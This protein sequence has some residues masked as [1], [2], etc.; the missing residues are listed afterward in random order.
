VTSSSSLFFTSELIVMTAYRWLPFMAGIMVVIWG[1]EHAF[2]VQPNG[3]PVSNVNLRAG[4]DTEYPVIVTVPNRAP[5]AILGCLGDHTWCDVVFQDS[6]GWMRSIYLAGW[7]QGYYYPLR[8][9]APRLGYPI[10]D[11]DIDEYW[12]AYYEDRPFYQERPRWSHAR[13]EGWVDRAVFYDRLE[14]YGDWVWLQGQYVWVPVN[15][16]RQWRP[17]TDGR[18]V[19]TDRH[20]WM[21]VSS[22]PFG[23]ATYH[24]GRWGFSNQVG[25]FWVPGSRWGPAWVSWRSSD[26]YLAWAPLPPAYDEGLS[27]NIAV[28]MVPD[29]YWQVVPTDRFLSVDL[30]RDIIRD[31]RRFEPL[32]RDTRPLGN[33]TI[34]NNNV[35]VNK[36][37]NVTYIE[38]KTHEKVVV[39]QVEKTEDATKAGKVE[40]AAVEVFQPAAGQA[41]KTAAPHKPKKIE[42]VAVES[43]TKGQGGGKPTTEGLLIP[44]EIQT[45]ADKAAS[46]PPSPSL[47]EEAAVPK[48]KPEGKQ[49]KAK[50]EPYPEGPPAVQP[51]GPP[52]PPPEEAEAPRGKPEG[53][54]KKAKGEPYPEGPPA[55]QPGGPPLPPP[56]E[57]EAPKGKPEGKQK[58]AKGEPYPEGPPAMQPGGPPLPPPEEAEAPR[59]KPDGKQKKAKGE[60][61]P[62]G[63]PAMRP[64]MAPPSPPAHDTQAPTGKP[65][66][67]QKKAKKGGAPCPEGTVPLDDGTCAPF[68]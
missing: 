2:A 30:R 42:E 61:Y 40:G 6:R 17:Y 44:P 65:E 5:I 60:P 66:G 12:D 18:W 34:I 19:Y 16:D 48:G 54:Q 13:E 58:K 32:L 33:V 31:E 22:E 23:W 57:A 63:P 67:K 39:H 10:V 46:P 51:G 49:K 24:Y 53:K 50:G 56:E 43:K 28:A 1:T 20:G 14:P 47:P 37:V 64:D 25:W 8:D 27:I 52:L 7:Y 55:M 9:Y 62:E 68:Q 38:Q 11:F 35:V 15:V 26:E 36:V 45:P 4:P 3:Y 21:W 41:P 29:Y 59:G